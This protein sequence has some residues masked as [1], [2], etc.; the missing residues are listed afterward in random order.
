MYTVDIGS[1]TLSLS[2]ESIS[3][4]GVTFSIDDLVGLTVVQT[5]V[6]VNGAWVNGVRRVVI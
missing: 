1:H 4:G 5:D 2:E 6:Y 3:F